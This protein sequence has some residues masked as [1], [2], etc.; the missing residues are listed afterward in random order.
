MNRMMVLLIVLMFSGLSPAFSQRPELSVE[1]W[2]HTEQRLDTRNIRRS[3]AMRTDTSPRF[4]EVPA[5]YGPAPDFDVAATPPTIDFGIVQGYEPWY[6]P[7][8]YQND[9]RHGGVWEGYGDV[10][11]G[12]DGCFYFSVGDHR[13]YN[14][15]AYI[16]RYDPAEKRQSVIFDLKK[17]AGFTA[18]EY[19]DSKIHGDL[20]IGPG[21]DVYFM[22]YFG[23]GPTQWHWDNEYTGS[24]L[25]RLNIFSGA[26]KNFGIPLEGSSWPYYNCDWERGIFFAAAERNG[27]VFV[28]DTDE[29]RMVYGGAPKHGIS[30]HRRCTMLDHETG[31][32]YATDTVTHPDG[33]RYRGDHHFVSY[34]RRNNEFRRLACA[35]PE[36]PVTGRA[37]PIRAHTGRKDA[38]GAFWCFSQ[39]GVFFTF[40]PAEEQTEYIGLN[41][42]DE[43]TY[44]TNMT[45]SPGGRY[46]YYVARGD[47]MPV[48]QFDTRTMRKKV[49]AFI[50]RFYLDEYGYCPAK[51][52][53]LELDDTGSSLFF[54]LDGGFA[55]ESA[56]LHYA[57][58]AMFHV[59][60][61]EG[62]R[63]D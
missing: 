47:G 27:V 59:F 4:L 62:E 20:D 49:I 21:G 6:L 32:W 35:V 55:E 26:V 17:A 13:G 46:I 45:L 8:L 56:S 3:P 1:D 23:P 12:P 38:S 61:P 53:G 29:E 42:G 44:I 19:A 41:W 9:Y 7:V 5:S 11:K 58:P 48:I 37:A 43:G 33:E 14:G 36:N 30:W 2:K 34:R 31:V 51:F 22:T 63:G 52:Y 28:F 16:I 25:F 54:Y 15:N 40:R 18:D 24:L 10:T 39:N 50:E 57:R 60:I